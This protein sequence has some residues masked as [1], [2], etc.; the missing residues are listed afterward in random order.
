MIY[1]THRL[2]VY[3]QLR[4]WGWTV[5]EALARCYRPGGARITLYT[6]TVVDPV[7]DKDWSPL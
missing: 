3:M 4:A 5:K 6:D 1:T 7:P 2:T